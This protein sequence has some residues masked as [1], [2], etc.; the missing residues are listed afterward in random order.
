[1]ARRR[2][3][4]GQFVK[5]TRRRAASRP[6]RKVTGRARRRVA[7]AV[8]NPRRRTYRRRRAAVARPRRRSYRRNPAIFSR[9]RILGM[10]IKEIAYTGIGFIAPPAIEGFVSAYLPTQITNTALGRYAVKGGIVAGVS[11]IGGKVVNRDAGKFMAIGGVTYIV[12]NLL[13]D[14]VPQLFSGFGSQPYLGK[15]PMRAYMNPGRTMG[16]Y[17]NASPPSNGG[18]ATADRL[19]P[20]SRF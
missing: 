13:L 5:S 8:A 20:A 16:R 15:S 10:S 17:L 3:S 18:G 2:N 12:A 11:M 1:M 14:Y 9:N 4:K 19:N 6:R 7:V